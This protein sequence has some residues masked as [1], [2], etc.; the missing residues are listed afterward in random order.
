MK[1]KSNDCGKCPFCNK[2]A[3]EYDCLDMVDNILYYPWICT[4]CGR[5]GEEWHTLKFIGH[6]VYDEDANC[7]EITKDMI[8]S[9][10]E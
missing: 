6:S 8:E 2:E 7:V 10:V 3:L 4:N 5:Q 1:V 9:E